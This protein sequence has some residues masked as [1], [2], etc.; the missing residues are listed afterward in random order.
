MYIYIL[1]IIIPTV[2]HSIIFQRVKYTN[3]FLTMALNGWYEFLRPLE[4]PC[5]SW[6]YPTSRQQVDVQWP[7]GEFYGFWKYNWWAIGLVN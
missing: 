2:T 6:M 5:E 4:R 7:V 1:G 3:Q